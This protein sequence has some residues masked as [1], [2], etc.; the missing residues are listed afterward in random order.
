MKNSSNYDSQITYFTYFRKIKPSQHDDLPKVSSDQATKLN[1][2][3]LLINAQIT[4]T[5]SLLESVSNITYII[6]V[7]VT[8]R[9]SYG[10][11]I[12]LLTLYMIVLPY[13][14]LMNTSH[15]KER[16]IE[17]GWMN[18]FTNIFGSNM[19]ILRVNDH[20]EP[21]DL[22]A[23]ISK[24]IHTRNNS[25]GK[26]LF[27][28]RS[29]AIADNTLIENQDTTKQ[30]LDIINIQDLEHEQP[31]TS[32]NID[33]PMPRENKYKSNVRNLISKMKS[34]IEE[35][36]E[37]IY[38]FQ[39]YVA[40][41]EKF[42]NGDND[43]ELDIQSDSERTKEK[44]QITSKAMNGKRSNCKKSV[45]T[46]KTIKDISRDETGIV[47]KTFK[48]L[49]FNGKK[50]VRIIERKEILEKILSKSINDEKLNFFIEEL[51]NLEESFIA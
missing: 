51:I 40:L 36:E 8:G 42:K 20:V 12:N 44:L 46:S 16:I 35:E 39:M 23:T 5:I 4:A 13:S 32:Q 47:F 6:L 33:E 50:S 29:K 26:E 38:Y 28:A 43:V 17:Q 41:V 37:Y 2:R 27:V 1:M 49:K 45:P 15:N 24:A 9:T 18:V 30:S 7:T 48:D 22:L 21:G 11:L 25:S 10:T 31:S 14:F 19:E 3:K 34:N